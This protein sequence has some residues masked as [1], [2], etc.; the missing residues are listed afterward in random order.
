MKALFII[1]LCFFHLA[2]AHQA[3]PENKL[4]FSYERMLAHSPS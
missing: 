2:L 4:S 3:L 1:L